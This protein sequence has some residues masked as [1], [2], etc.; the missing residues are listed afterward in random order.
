MARNDLALLGGKKHVSDHWHCKY[1]DMGE[2]EIT[3][4]VRTLMRGELSAVGY[5][6]AVGEMQRK[7][8]NYFGMRYAHAFNSGTASIH[9]AL[10]AAGVG[11]GA[12]V[13][14]PNN[15][16]ISAICAIMHAGGTPIFCDTAPNSQHIDP[17]E[18]DRKVTP[19][20]KAVIVTHIWGLPADMTPIL[21]VAK[22]HK[23]IVIEDCSHAHGGK[24]KGKYLGTIGD[25]GCFSLQGS[26]GIVAGEGGVMV[27]NSKLLYERAM[28]PSFHIARLRKDLTLKSVEPFQDGGGSWTYRIPPVCAAIASAQ[29]DKLETYTQ[30]R[31][32]NL[33]RLLAGIGKLSL[34]RWPKLHRDSRR[35]FY[36]T[37]ALY[38]YEQ[39]KVSRDLFCQAAAAEGV[40]IRG[41]GY[42]NYY[43][44]PIF[45]DTKLYG[46]LWPVKH[47]NGVEYKPL[48]AGAL[49]NNEKLRENQL[50]LNPPH[51]EMFDM[52]DEWAEA[53][54]KIASNMDAL[55]RHQRKEKSANAA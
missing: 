28:V 18:I 13:L 16:W 39:S 51:V 47:A 17:K 36:G 43:Q 30:A 53:I 54:R 3:G 8:A 42:D 12:E 46:Q 55:A 37:P 9:G 10:F 14:T 21:K 7:Y 24:Y 4:A 11:P 33:D 40:G 1:P 19:N 34:I 32:A 41:N 49:K 2:E 52:M 45:Q 38:N 44:T 26:K 22:K 48:A 23:L 27:T 20:T 6:G 31:Q 5:D 35:G 50:I 15:T 25:I 29:L